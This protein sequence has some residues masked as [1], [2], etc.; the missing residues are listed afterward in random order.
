VALAHHRKNLLV[1]NAEKIEDFTS[2]LLTE[3]ISL[4]SKSNFE[5]Y[6]ILDKMSIDIKAKFPAS[7]NNKIVVLSKSGTLYAN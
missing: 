6:I 2:K 3:I 4:S 1:L 5:V 7:K